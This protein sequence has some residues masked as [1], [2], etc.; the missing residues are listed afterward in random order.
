MLLPKLNEKKI[1][2]EDIPCISEMYELRKNDLEAYQMIR[3]LDII[4]DIHTFYR[5]AFPVLD[6]NYYHLFTALAEE[7]SLLLEE[8]RK[9]IEAVELE[10]SDEVRD[11]IWDCIIESIKNKEK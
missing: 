9:R 2:M 8:E 4:A 10:I 7:N 1:Q 11:K 6:Y 3:E 5:I